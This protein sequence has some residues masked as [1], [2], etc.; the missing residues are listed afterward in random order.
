MLRQ[1]VLI[2]ARKIRKRI[3]KYFTLEN[4]L[5][6]L[7][8]YSKRFYVISIGFDQIYYGLKNSM[9][10]KICVLICTFMW[11][12]T[13]FQL[14]FVISDHIYSLGHH[15]NLPNFLRIIYLSGILFTTLITIIKTDFLF[16]EINYNLEPFKV[17]HFL[18]NNMK[19]KHKLTNVN[20]KRL[21]IY[22][23]F[24]V[25]Y[26]MN[27]STMFGVIAAIS[28]N[29]TMTIL[30]RKLFWL[31]QLIIMTPYY[32]F[33]IANGAAWFCF[34]FIIFIYYK[35]IF[36]QIN[37]RLES[38]LSNRKMTII[39]KRREKL[40]LRLIC[41][42]NLASIQI[43]KINLML[44]RSAAAW[45]F[46]LA[47][48]KIVSLYLMINIENIFLVFAQIG[49]L[50][51]CFVFAF[52]LSYLFSRQIKSAHKS[53]NLIVSSACQLKMRVP[54]RIKVI[55]YYKLIN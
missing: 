18:M 30:S 3:F 6:D 32:L 5:N 4:S 28:V 35:L 37:D 29:I 17:F 16:A 2:Y 9:R 50:I 51:N 1:K 33:V 44:N 24:I 36:D 54:F 34:I 41:E 19:S 48:I 45:F 12:S 20:Y 25:I 14:S 15:P 31:F 13:L 53:H 27:Y 23:R 47:V 49:I 52:G 21:A 46:I 43:N 42:H 8:N 22:T 7:M 55:Q 11:L 26:I 38:L 10:F 40:I 39:N